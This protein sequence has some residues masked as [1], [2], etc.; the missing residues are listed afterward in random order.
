LAINRIERDLPAALEQVLTAATQRQ[1]VAL[2]ELIRREDG[3]G[4]AAEAII[5]LARSRS[6]AQGSRFSANQQSAD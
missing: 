3:A 6:S 1:A 2:G 5:A 4:N